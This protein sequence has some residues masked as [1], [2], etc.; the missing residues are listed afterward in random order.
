LPFSLKPDTILATV[1]LKDKK[2][3][4]ERLTAAFCT[5]ADRT[6]KIKLFVI[7]KSP[8]PRCFK[9]VNRNKLGIIYR[10]SSKAWMIT[11]LF[12]KW[13]KEFDLKMAS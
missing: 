10:A 9:G 2:K 5:N 1:R 11:I 13:L 7:G 3:D 8:N 12:Q 6:N 4:K